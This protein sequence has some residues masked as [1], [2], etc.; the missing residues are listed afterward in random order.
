MLPQYIQWV[1]MDCGKE[2]G[3]SR[4]SECCTWH[5]GKCDICG[6]TKEVTE[7]RDFGHLRT[8]DANSLNALDA[9]REGMGW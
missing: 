4:P 2:H 3:R 9:M 8:T 7:P 6:Q 1:C 5:V